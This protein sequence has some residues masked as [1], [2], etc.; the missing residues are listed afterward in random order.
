MCV[1]AGGVVLCRCVCVCDLLTFFYQCSY[2]R[3]ARPA[4]DDDNDTGGVNP[5]EQHPSLEEES[6]GSGAGGDDIGGEGESKRSASSVF[7]EMLERG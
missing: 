4:P 6:D 3:P 1:G 7:A 5:G 2:S